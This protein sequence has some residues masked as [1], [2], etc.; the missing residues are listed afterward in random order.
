M[1]SGKDQGVSIKLTEFFRSARRSNL[2][3]DAKAPNRSN[4]TRARKKVP[5]TVFQ[6]ILSRAVALANDLWPRDDS[7]LWRKMSVYAF[8]GSKFCLPATTELRAEFDLK[9]GLENNGKGHYPQCL[10]MTAYDVFRQLPIARAVGTINSSERD[11]AQ[12]LLSLIPSNSV[13]LFDRG[14]PSYPFIKHLRENHKGYY[15]FRC[16]AQSTFPAVE[17]FIEQGKDE[18]FIILT[19]SSNFLHRARVKERKKAPLIQLRVIRLE[20]P[21][22]TL[23]VLLTNLLNKKAFPKEQIIDLYFRRWAI[24][25]HYRNEKSILGLEQFHGK[26]SNSIRQELF[27]VL[28]MTVIARTLMVLASKNLKR[29]AGQCQFKNAIVVLASEAAVLVPDNPQKAATI[30]SEILNQISAVKY[31]RPKTPRPSQPRVTKRAHNK[32]CNNRPGKLAGP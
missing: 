20:N 29:D 5:W 23:S 16:S 11:L 21:D 30:F 13:L 3:H 31:Y 7:Y 9:S 24:E 2:W 32:W 18:D 6:D 4:V 17:E 26:T 28:I 25:G 10:V 12:S 22:G 1:A 8:D 27:A 15:L 19:P 14:F